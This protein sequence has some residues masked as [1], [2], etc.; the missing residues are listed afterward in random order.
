MMFDKLLQNLDLG[1]LLGNLG[2]VE[3]LAAKFGIPAD[4]V[5]NILGSLTEKMGQGGDQM[6]SLMEA[7]QEHGLSVDSLK[8]LFENFTQGGGEGSSPL[9]GLGDM[10]GKLTGKE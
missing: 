6:T 8:G 5:Q 3:E 1:S 2:N 9:G 4:Q 10:L 7:A